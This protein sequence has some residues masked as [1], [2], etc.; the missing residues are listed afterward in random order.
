MESNITTI[1]GLSQPELDYLKEYEYIKIDEI[2]FIRKDKVK[3]IV[4]HT[5]EKITKN[6]NKS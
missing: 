1:D 4:N 5:L 2:L 3:E 6:V